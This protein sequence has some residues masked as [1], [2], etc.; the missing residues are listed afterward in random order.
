MKAPHAP[1]HLRAGF[2]LIE[3]LVVIAIIAILAGMLLPALSRAKTQAK[4][5]VCQNNQRQLALSMRLYSEDTGKWVNYYPGSADS[6]AAPYQ[7]QANPNMP[8][9]IWKQD[10]NGNGAIVNMITWMDTVFP[11][12]GNLSLYRCGAVPVNAPTYAY[13]N[14]G[15][16]GYLGGR[17]VGGGF[18]FRDITSDGAYAPDK[19]LVTA[20]YNLPW[21]YFM[22]AGDWGVQAQNP[23]GQGAAHLYKHPAVYRHNERSIVSFADGSVGFAENADTSYYGVAGINGHFNPTFVR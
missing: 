1:R 4:M 11:Y 20:D 21:A 14:Y 23:V 3:L 5:P 13:H 22:N 10:Y 6:P 8:G 17:M 2:T 16:N 19:V 7:I 18:G 9:A 15:Y 12:A